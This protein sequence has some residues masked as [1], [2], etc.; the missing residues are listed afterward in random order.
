ML[1]D[2]CI[3]VDIL[4]AF[5]SVGF[6]FGWYCLLSLLTWFCWLL[7]LLCCECWIG[8]VFD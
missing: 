7:L 5:V 2:F 3:G 4:L 1:F 8:F 6:D